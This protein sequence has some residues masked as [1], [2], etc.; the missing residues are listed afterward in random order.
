MAA[1][2]LEGL[3]A[4]YWDYFDMKSYYLF[5]FVPS[6]ELIEMTSGA[7]SES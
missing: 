7:S 5:E 4:E 1:G 6:R 3:E 2:L